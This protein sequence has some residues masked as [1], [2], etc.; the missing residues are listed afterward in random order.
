MK[1]YYITV[2]GMNHYYGLAPFSVGKVLKCYKEPSNPYD[3]EAI[4]VKLKEV[5]NISDLRS[6]KNYDKHPIHLPRHYLCE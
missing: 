4:V 6:Y 1:D 5:G 3:N 2:T